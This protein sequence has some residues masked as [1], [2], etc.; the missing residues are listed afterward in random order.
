MLLA[1]I[2]EIAQKRKT[3]CP[4]LFF[5]GLTPDPFDWLR[6][7]TKYSKGFRAP[8]SDETYFTFEHPLFTIRPNSNLMFGNV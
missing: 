6:V 3:R 8:T 4:F 1:R 7:Q 5:L 2:Q